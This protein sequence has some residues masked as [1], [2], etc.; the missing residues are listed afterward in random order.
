MGRAYNTHYEPRNALWILVSKPEG[1]YRMFR[2]QDDLTFILQSNF[3]RKSCATRQEKR[4]RAVPRTE[5]SDKPAQWTPCITYGR[6]VRRWEDNIKLTLK[7]EDMDSINLG[8]D[9]DP[10]PT[11]TKTVMTRRVPWNTVNFF[12]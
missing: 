8:R 4:R 6:V 11:L 3:L 2:A 1:I 9:A 12:F 5:K 7:T 10:W